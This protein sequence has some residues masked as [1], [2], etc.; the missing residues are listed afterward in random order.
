[1]PPLQRRFIKCFTCFKLYVKN[2]KK[3]VFNK[4]K[5]AEIDKIFEAVKISAFVYLFTTDFI[6][7]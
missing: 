2:I 1:M 5:N 6:L 7:T 4:E 3:I